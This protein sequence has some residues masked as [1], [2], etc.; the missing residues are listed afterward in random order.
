MAAIGSTKK[1]T[2]VYIITHTDD[3]GR[4][5]HCE[6]NTLTVVFLWN[7]LSRRLFTSLKRP[8]Q[9]H[10]QMICVKDL[11]GHSNSEMIWP[12]RFM[13]V[14][15]IFPV[16]RS[17]GGQMLL[18]FAYWWSQTNNNL[19]RFGSSAS[20]RLKNTTVLSHSIDWYSTLHNFGGRHGIG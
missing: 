14:V 5:G 7:S 9:R 20:M 18:Q 13:L 16:Y 17:T 1:K 2:F 19:L 12:L 3:N 10:W 6:S 11:R 15:G 8:T 4:L